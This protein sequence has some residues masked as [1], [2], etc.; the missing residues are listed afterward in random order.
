MLELNLTPSDQGMDWLQFIAALVGA[1]AWPIAVVVLAFIF[2]DPITKILGNMKRVS[3]GD[4][5]L[6]IAETLT[7][8][9]AV[10]HTPSD[11]PIPAIE[12]PEGEPSTDAPT[13][14]GGPAR[15]SSANPAVDEK[16]SNWSKLTDFSVF[17]QYAPKAGNEDIAT[18]LIAQK[19][20]GR[21]PAARINR[22]WDRV[23]EA[24]AARDGDPSKAWGPPAKVPVSFL[25]A[26]LMM[27]K[28]ITPRLYAMLEEMDRIRKAAEDA[29]TLDA[30]R[31]HNL[32]KNVLEELDAIP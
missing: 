18:W 7:V 10:A 8:L 16:S 9:E 19:V 12:H 13:Q 22:D 26:S 5:S 3:V 25:L 21:S 1:A 28:R 4:A 15:A 31:F 11:E 2:R 27:Q 32:A 20:A 29:S 6:E 23:V 24:L 14:E 30:V 17:D